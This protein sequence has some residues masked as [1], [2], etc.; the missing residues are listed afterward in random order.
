MIGHFFWIHTGIAGELQIVWDR[1][2]PCTW[3][4][5]RTALIGINLVAIHRFFFSTPPLL[6]RSMSPSD[7]QPPCRQKEILACHCDHDQNDHDDYLL[8]TTFAIPSHLSL[9]QCCEIPIISL[10]RADFH[11]RSGRISHFHFQGL[12]CWEKKCGN[13]K[14]TVKNE[15]RKRQRE[16]ASN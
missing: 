4:P 10:M 14:K 11:S 9:L 16:R 8:L 7:P 12:I 3:H 2:G 13:N 15:Y 6:Q 5:F 1:F